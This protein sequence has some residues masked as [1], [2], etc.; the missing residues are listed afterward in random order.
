[1]MRDALIVA[2]FLFPIGLGVAWLLWRTYLNKR[3]ADR[4]S[5]P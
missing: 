5:A 4:E 1:M 3:I 2:A